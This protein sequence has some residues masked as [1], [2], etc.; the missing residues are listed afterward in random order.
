M[1]FR[2]LHYRFTKYLRQKVVISDFDNEQQ[3]AM[4]SMPSLGWFNLKHKLVNSITSLIEQLYYDKP[5]PHPKISMLIRPKGVEPSEDNSTK[6]RYINPFLVLGWIQLILGLTR[7]NEP[8]K[9][10]FNFKNHFCGICDRNV[11]VYLFHAMGIKCSIF[12]LSFYRI[13]DYCDCG[14]GRLATLCINYLNVK[15]RSRNVFIVIRITLR[16][17]S[18]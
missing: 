14:H 18:H 2:R 5:N 9:N 10:I 13:N 6:Q 1:G 8:W 16:R 12:Y 11:C 7:A 15:R 3:V 17:C 4:V